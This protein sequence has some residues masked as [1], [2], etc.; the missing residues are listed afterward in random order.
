MT[1]GAD[2]SAVQDIVMRLS[3][4]QHCHIITPHRVVYD[5]A[6]EL[7]VANFEMQRLFTLAIFLEME[8]D[9]HIAQV[10]S[11]EVAGDV[12]RLDELE[13]QAAYLENLRLMVKDFFRIEAGKVNPEAWQYDSLDVT[14]DW[15]LLGL[16]EGVYPP[17]QSRG[18][19]YPGVSVN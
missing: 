16:P 8:R 14:P 11:A 10:Q 18:Y 3:A 19:C 1:S 2:I 5:D 6:D 9:T 12:A 4:V 13:W 15:E 17:D 7:G